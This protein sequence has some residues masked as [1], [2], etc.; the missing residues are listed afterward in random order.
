MLK[1]RKIY[2]INNY[3]LKKYIQYKYEKEKYNTT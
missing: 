2:E 1:D 3:L